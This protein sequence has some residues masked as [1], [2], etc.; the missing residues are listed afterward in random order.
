[1]HKIKPVHNYN[2]NDNNNNNINDT[3]IQHMVFLVQKQ[4]LNG[5]PAYRG[6]QCTK[7]S[8]TLSNGWLLLTGMTVH[9]SEGKTIVIFLPILPGE[10]LLIYPVER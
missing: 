4:S 9:L 5:E 10:E 2:K 6:H 3:G 7:V 1:M 8:F